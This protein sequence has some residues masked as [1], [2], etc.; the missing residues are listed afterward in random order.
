[1]RATHHLLR[2]DVRA[3]AL[4]MQKEPVAVDTPLGAGT[5]HVAFVISCEKR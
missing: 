2:V 1:M 4:G 5:E 3:V